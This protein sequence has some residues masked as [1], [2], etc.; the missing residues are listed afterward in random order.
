MNPHATFLSRRH[1]LRRSAEAAVIGG[2]AAP[3]LGQG[4]EAAASRF[5]Y[6][7][8]RFTKTD[9]QWLRYDPDGRFPTP[10][11]Q[12][13]RISIGPGG[14][15]Y[16]AAQDKVCVVDLAGTL[17]ATL[18]LNDVARCAIAGE[19]G[20]VYAATRN[21]V[22]VFEAGGRE[23]LSWEVPGPKAWV[24]ALALVGDSVLAADSGNRV[25]WRFDLSGK[26]LGR[27]GEK[28][29]EREIP[30][31]VVPSPYLDVEPGKDGLLRVNNPGRHRVELYTLEGDLELFWGKASAGVGGFCGCCNPIAVAA[32]PDGRCITCEKGLPRVKIFALDGAFEGV[33]AGPESFPQ[34]ARIGSGRNPVDGTLGGLDATVDAR[35]RVYVLD[36]VASEVQ[37]FKP[38]TVS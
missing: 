21:R 33:V 36:L 27:I 18:S 19:D 6:D 17:E 11:P 28:D 7:V 13:K 38:K 22:V 9:P 24:S 15:F 3:L 35:G 10:R 12:A 32:L 30:G 2:V 20:L 14:R 8:E 29:Q 37:I 25:I 16:I 1:F 23:K 4:A 34:N 5:A 31:F 26:V